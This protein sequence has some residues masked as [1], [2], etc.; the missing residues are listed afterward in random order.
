M[1][2]K[3]PVTQ[4]E[5]NEQIR[6]EARAT[7]LLFV[8]C[9]V[10]HI[11]WA[12]ALSG[13]GIKLFGLPLWWLLSTPGVFVVAVVGLAYLLRHVFVDFDLNEEEEA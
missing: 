8:I 6:R 13:S 2:K 10:W 12:L 5:K 9:A 11:G 4:A 1:E 3:Q 7:V